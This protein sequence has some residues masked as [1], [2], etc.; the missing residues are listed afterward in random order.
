M[1]NVPKCLADTFVFCQSEQ[2]QDR[3]FDDIFSSTTLFNLEIYSAKEQL[4]SDA[5]VD[6]FDSCQHHHSHCP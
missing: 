5:H 2:E 1:N 3:M 6:L 4:C